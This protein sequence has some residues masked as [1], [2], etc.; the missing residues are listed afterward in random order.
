LARNYTAAEIGHNTPGIGYGKISSTNNAY[1]G[2]YLDLPIAHLA[3]MC[4]SRTQ[5]DWLQEGSLSTY[6]LPRI[7]ETT[8]AMR[9][10]TY[11]MDVKFAPYNTIGSRDAE[12]NF[13]TYQGGETRGCNAA[14]WLTYDHTTLKGDE[15]NANYTAT[16]YY[17][18]AEASTRVLISGTSGVH[19]TEEC[20]SR[21][22]LQDMMG[23]ANEFTS[24]MTNAR[25]SINSLVD[26]NDLAVSWM[27][28][29]GTNRTDVFQADIATPAYISP[30]TGFN[31]RC[32]S[33]CVADDVI[34]PVSTIYSYRGLFYI[35]AAAAPNY[36]LTYGGYWSRGGY[37]LKLYSRYNKRND[38]I[39]FQD[40]GRCVI[41]VP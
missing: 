4:N 21:Y 29:D 17:P 6:R 9:Y 18:H 12:H 31:L 37:E 28:F 3:G 39:W 16:G 32:T 27:N 11:Y 35:D 23:N 19:S 8:Q 34:R 2:V 14:T 20:V 30:V 38:N 36:V 40:S 22:G 13:M 5:V 1:Q 10:P 41:E 26:A 15:S 7:L 33:G 25:I 24:S